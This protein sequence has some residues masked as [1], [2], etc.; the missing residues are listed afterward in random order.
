[1]ITESERENIRE[2]LKAYVEKFSSQ[3]KAAQSLNGT[4]AGTINA[5]LNGEQDDKISDVMWRTIAA[6]VGG[7]ASSSDEWTVVSTYAFR[8]ITS[9]ME[10]A[11]QF[12]NVTW[13]T[14]EAGSGKSTTAKAYRDTHKDVFYILC[15]EDMH[16]SVFVREIARTIG[17]RSEGFALRELWQLILNEIVQMDSPLLIFDEADKLGE[18]VFQYFVSMYNKIE[19]RAGM[20]FLSTD[21]I[22]QRI[23]NGLRYGRPGYKEFYS[24]IGRKF[25]DL[26][27]TDNNDIAAI[28]MANGVTDKKLIMEVIADASNYEY[29]F[30]RVKKFIHTVKRTA[31]QKKQ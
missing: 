22:K 10:D 4:S 7:L 12:R 23:G 16:R 14:G 17:I 11:Q 24:R 21:T 29:D 27:P 2:K 26:A 13:V 8:E 15:A 28:C 30:R 5:I 20:V 19:D 31:V 18:S 3:R 6:Q 9:V 25:F 1:M